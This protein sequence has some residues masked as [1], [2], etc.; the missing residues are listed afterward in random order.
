[1]NNPT[2]AKRLLEE[3]TPTEGLAVKIEELVTAIR[4]EAERRD[5]GAGTIVISA[6]RLRY[7]MRASFLA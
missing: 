5:L 3:R 4:L 1:M 6:Q 2:T 7:L